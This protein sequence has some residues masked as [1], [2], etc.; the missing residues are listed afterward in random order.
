VDQSIDI[1]LAKQRHDGIIEGW[2]GDGNSARTAIMYALMKT[3]GVTASPWREDL[4]LG[5]VSL[6]D[7]AIAISLECEWP[8]NGS[9][10]F[11]RPRHSEYF[12]MPYDYP[13]LNQFAEWFVVEADAQYEVG[14]LGEE[15]A[16]ISGPDLRNF[17]V[18]ITPEEPL[19]LLVRRK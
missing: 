5:A 3:Q 19:R 9:L 6:G 15:P 11:D 8:W 12:Q 16:E 4:Q 2:H 14:R 13:R 17:S 7:D 10:R 18:S 1:L